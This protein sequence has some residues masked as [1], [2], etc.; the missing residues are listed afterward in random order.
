MVPKVDGASVKTSPKISASENYKKVD[1]ATWDA[2]FGGTWSFNGDG[3]SSKKCFQLG[4]GIC[5]QSSLLEVWD[6]DTATIDALNDG[7][8][9][10]DINA[11]ADLNLVTVASSGTGGPAGSPGSYTSAKALYGFYSLSET[12]MLIEGKE[13]RLVLPVPGSSPGR[14]L[15]LIR[16]FF[17]RMFS[18][19][20]SDLKGRSDFGRVGTTCAVRAWNPD[21]GVRRCMPG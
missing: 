20:P 18:S 12:K 10:S 2:M 4:G 21:R 3:S 15:D 5:G 19:C 6:R 8:A 13:V 9:L 11:E 1:Q 14:N 16:P 17:S 7:T